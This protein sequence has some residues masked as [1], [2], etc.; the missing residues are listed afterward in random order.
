MN[1]NVWGLEKQPLLL[2]FEEMGAKREEVLLLFMFGGKYFLQLFSFGI[3]LID[4]PPPP[5]AS[6]SDLSMTQSYHN[7][8]FLPSLLQTNSIMYYNRSEGS[9]PLLCIYCVQYFTYINMLKPYSSLKRDVAAYFAENKIK[10]LS[11]FTSGHIAIKQY[12]HNSILLTSDANV[13][14]HSNY[15]LCSLPPTSPDCFMKD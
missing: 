14:A 15:A 12:L 13:C 5:I 3:L 9:C 11:N 7:A 8:I 10:R 2:S 1:A 4:F 6:T